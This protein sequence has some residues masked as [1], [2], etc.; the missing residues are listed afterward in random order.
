M[1]LLLFLLG[2]VLKQNKHKTIAYFTRSFAHRSQVFHCTYLTWWPHNLPIL[3]PGARFSK[4]PVTFRAWSYIF[5]KKPSVRKIAFQPEKLLG[6]LR[7]GPQVTELGKIAGIL[8]LCCH[9]HSSLS[10]FTWHKKPPKAS[11]KFQGLLK[12]K[13]FD[14]YRIYPCNSRSH[15]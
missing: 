3:L 8:Q 14:S 7:N 2:A 1:K 5:K 6:L 13:H 15:V 4:V 10:S 11:P 9:L 12:F